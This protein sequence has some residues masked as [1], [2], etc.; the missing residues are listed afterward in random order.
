MEHCFKLTEFCRVQPNFVFACQN[1]ITSGSF[2]RVLLA[3][4]AVHQH[5]TRYWNQHLGGGL[6]QPVQ[7]YDHS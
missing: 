4:P 2:S 5:L 7:R 1:H 3:S 6:Y